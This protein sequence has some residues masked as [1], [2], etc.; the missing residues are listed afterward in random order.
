MKGP[1]A[2]YEDIS[3]NQLFTRY[4]Q[5]LFSRVTAI[6]EKAGNRRLLA[7]RMRD[8][9]ANTSFADFPRLC[10]L[11]AQ[12]GFLPRAFAS[13]GR[14]L[15]Y[16]LGI[17]VLTGLSAFLL[18]IFG[19]VT[20][21]LIPLLAVGA[22]LAFTLSQ[23]GMVG[24]WRLSGGPGRIPAMLVNGVGALATGATRLIVIVAKFVEGAWVMTILIPALLAVFLMV[25]RHCRTV[26]AEIA[27]PL[28]LNV[29]NFQPPIVII[30]MSQWNRI[31][32]KGLRFAL[33][34]SRDILVV[35]VMAGAQTE[36]DLSGKWAEFVQS[37]T[38]ARALAGSAARHNRLAVPSRV[39]PA[40]RLHPRREAQVAGPPD[41]GA[42]PGTH[43]PTLVSPSAAQ[44]TCRHA[45]GTPARARRRRHRGHQR[46]LVPGRTAFFGRSHRCC[47][48]A[49][50]S[51]YNVG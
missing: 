33:K 2:G 11:I 51:S 15:V 8:A 38:R 7:K 17:Y 36:S 25:A 23:A 43:R 30:P 49:N 1:D 37:P 16:S 31:S 44:Q 35:Q 32:Q 41:R 45:E 5:L 14:R 28:P 6:A 27:N 48:R 20:D 13:R 46:A 26:A 24:H 21:R 4:E 18:I 40:D 39:Q 19:G 34:H 9:T 22:F 47:L 12:D 50:G 29:T 3:Q 10:R 42:P